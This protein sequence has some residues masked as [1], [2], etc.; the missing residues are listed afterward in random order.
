VAQWLERDCPRERRM[1]LAGLR[2]Q[3]GLHLPFYLLMKRLA[4]TLLPARSFH[5]LGHRFGRM[6]RA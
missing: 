4:R 1:R 2:Y 6:S 3:L 5:W